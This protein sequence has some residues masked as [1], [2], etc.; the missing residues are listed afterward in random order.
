M[1]IVTDR[2][3]G[4]IIFFMDGEI[5]RKAPIVAIEAFIGRTVSHL[6]NARESDANGTK[7]SVVYFVE[8]RITGLHPDAAFTTKEDLM[9][10]LFDNL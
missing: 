6:A 4:E 9:K 10:S 2:N 7:V 1:E 3:V 5:P 8:D